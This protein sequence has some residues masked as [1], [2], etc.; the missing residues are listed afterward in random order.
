MTTKVYAVTDGLGN[1]LRFLLSSGNRN[2]ICMAQT[3]PEPF[4]LRGRPILAD[5]GYDGDKFGRTRRNCSYSQPRQHK[6]S[7]TYRLVHIQGAP[8]CGKS[9]SQVQ[10]Q[11]SLCHQIREKDALFSCCC[12]PCLFPCLV[13]LMVLK[14]TLITLPEK[15]ISLGLWPRLPH[16]F[17]C[18]M[19]LLSEG[20]GR[21]FN[22][23]IANQNLNKI[24]F[25]F[26]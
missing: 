20:E 15:Y 22:R 8:S 26:K 2:D 13:T 10:K 24:K 7:Q 11:P 18:G 12:L 9:V 25:L 4:D 23:K 21:E 17:V 16:T 5:K 1:P 3:L 6:A 14:Q 19:L